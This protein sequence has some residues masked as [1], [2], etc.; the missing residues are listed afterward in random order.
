ML[1]ADAACDTGILSKEWIDEDFVQLGNMIVAA[2]VEHLL[3]MKELDAHRM[4]GHDNG[5]DVSMEESLM[6]K[7]KCMY[8][9]RHR[10]LVMN[11]ADMELVSNYAFSTSIVGG[12]STSMQNQIIPFVKNRNICEDSCKAFFAN[13]APS[14][15]ANNATIVSGMWRGLEI[16]KLLLCTSNIK[17][18]SEVL[19][20]YGPPESHPDV[21]TSKVSV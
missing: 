10:S 21:Y 5:Y 15:N 19:T 4:K 16:V 17:A 13:T 3:D 14:G 2:F 9:E 1:N 7:S 11:L 8:E 6:R 12:G 20:S 18:G